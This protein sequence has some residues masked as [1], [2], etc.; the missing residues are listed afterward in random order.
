MDT[1]YA[2]SASVT[3]WKNVVPPVEQLPLPPDVM[4]RAVDPL[5]SAPPESPGSAQTVVWIMPRTTPLPW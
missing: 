3:G 1:P 4:P 2:L 5:Y